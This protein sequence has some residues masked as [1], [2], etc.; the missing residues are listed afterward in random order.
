MFTRFG[1][2][3]ET[4]ARDHDDFFFQ[5]EAEVLLYGATK[6]GAYVT[7]Q[8]EPDGTFTMRLCLPDK[9]QVIPAVSASADGVEQRTV[10]VAI[11]RNTKYME[12]LIREAA[13]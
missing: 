12:P 7:V 5:V 11:E 4:L 9:R 3:A 6:P 8:G 10:V 1:A 13:D 2:G